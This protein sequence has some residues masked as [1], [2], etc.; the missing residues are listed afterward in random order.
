MWMNIIN[1]EIV[2]LRVVVSEVVFMVE[3]EEEKN[4]II[5]IREIKI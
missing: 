5:K 1:S 2:K 3:I 4:K